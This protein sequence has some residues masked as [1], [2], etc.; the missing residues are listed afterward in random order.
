MTPLNFSHFYSLVGL[1]INERA[2]VGVEPRK[3]AASSQTKRIEPN[4]GF[5]LE[6]TMR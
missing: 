5:E 2:F 3:S 4:P 1:P 6:L